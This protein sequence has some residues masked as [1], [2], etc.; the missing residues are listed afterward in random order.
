VV[1]FNYVVRVG[2]GV[3]ISFVDGFLEYAAE[4]LRCE[5]EI[6]PSQITYPFLYTFTMPTCFSDF[7][8]LDTNKDYNI[9]LNG[10]ETY[11]SEVT[12]TINGQTE[13]KLL[14][15]TNIICCNA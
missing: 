1:R 4:L 9:D 11:I 6:Q 14:S 10:V 3:S 5:N 8:L 12:Q 2:L 7:E 15:N 13:F